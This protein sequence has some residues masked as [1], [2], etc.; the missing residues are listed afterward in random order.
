METTLIYLIA[1]FILLLIALFIARAVFS[2]PA[3]IRYQKAIIKLLALQAK[4]SGVP[5]EEINKVINAAKEDN[6]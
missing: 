1:A 4:N 6:K 2:I 5:V 3:F